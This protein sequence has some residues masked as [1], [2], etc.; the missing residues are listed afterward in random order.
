MNNQAKQLRKLL[1]IVV[2]VGVVLYGGYLGIVL[3][4]HK[5]HGILKIV[6]VPNDATVLL[7]SKHVTANGTVLVKA[8]DHTLTSSR[9]GFQNTKNQFTIKNGQ[10]INLYLYP[11]PTS[12]VGEK[13]L[14]Q[15]PDLAHQREGVGGQ[16]H[17]ATVNNAI[18]Q[19]SFITQLPYI[20]AGYEYRIDYGDS[21]P[22]NKY[23]DQPTIIITGATQAAQDD[24]ITWMR[25]NNYNPD[26]MN[27]KF[28]TA[29]PE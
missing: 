7:D 14:E 27:I 29:T 2:I 15:N 9:A 26:T 4:Q 5:T 23:P 16:E 25:N 28:V 8:G 21:N 24:A 22:N 10:T 20:G 11:K 12:D 13:W 19:N 17:A 18:Q 1:I 3:W 6:S